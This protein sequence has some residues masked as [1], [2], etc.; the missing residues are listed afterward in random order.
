[1]GRVALAAGVELHEL[2]PST[3]NLEQ[4]FFDLTQGSEAERESA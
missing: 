1:V 3:G 2:T 4:V